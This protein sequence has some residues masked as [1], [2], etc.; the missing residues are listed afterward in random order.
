MRDMCHIGMSMRLVILADKQSGWLTF[1]CCSDE[2]EFP[3]LYPVQLMN[4]EICVA[5]AVPS[6]LTQSSLLKLLSEKSFR[7]GGLY[8]P[9]ILFKSNSKAL[10]HQ[11]CVFLYTDTTC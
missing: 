9:S 11:L 10:L 4:C 8:F 5:P 3:L 7:F 2:S 1:T 6:A